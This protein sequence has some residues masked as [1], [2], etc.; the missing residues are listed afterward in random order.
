MKSLNKLVAALALFVPVVAAAEPL[1]KPV[2][3]LDCL[4]GAWT[5]TGTLTMGKDKAKLSGA[6]DCKRTSAKFG[7]A[8]TLRITGIPGLPVYEETDLFG[9]EANTNTYHWFSV[10]NSGETHDHVAKLPSG[11]TAQFEFNGIQGGKAF[12]EI[13]SFTFSNDSKNLA[14]RS[15]SFVA[16]TSTALMEFGVHK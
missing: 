6:W 4:V 10:T 3:D 7:V 5:G 13:V 12:K 8:C 1:P 9:Y 2:S 11:N 15:E 14:V 16:G